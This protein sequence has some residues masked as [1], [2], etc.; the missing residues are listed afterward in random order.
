MTHGGDRMTTDN[1]NHP[2]HYT[3]HES[4]LECI[5]I[6]RYL[7]YSLGN[8]IKYLWRAGLKSKNVE[9]DLKKAV[10][11][12]K[13][14]VKNDNNIEYS[15]SLLRNLEFF[16]QNTEED[17]NLKVLLQSILVNKKEDLNNSIKYYIKKLEEHVEDLEFKRA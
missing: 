6:V 9:E 15:L 7:P 5:D 13:D 12:F 3:S 2:A 10:W 4:G 16:I 14:F 17:S 11:Y 1:I 8:A